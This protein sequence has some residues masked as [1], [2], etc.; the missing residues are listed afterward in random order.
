[1]RVDRRRWRP[2]DRLGV[3][4][5][6]TLVQQCAPLGLPGRRRSAIGC[7][8]WSASAIEEVGWMEDRDDYD[9]DHP[10]DQRFLFL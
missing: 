8:G 5:V 9:V 6:F 1:M 10:L 4:R 3:Q 7:V 2:H